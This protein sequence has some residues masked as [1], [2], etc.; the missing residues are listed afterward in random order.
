MLCHG[1]NFFWIPWKP[2]AFS[3]SP[4]AVGWP[5]HSVPFGVEGS[6]RTPQRFQ[7]RPGNLRISA[8]FPLTTTHVVGERLWF[9][10]S[11]SIPL[12]NQ[13]H[14]YERGWWFKQRD[15][16]LCPNDLSKVT[17][18][19]AAFSTVWGHVS[20]LT[21]SPSHKKVTWKRRIARGRP[22]LE[23]EFLQKKTFNKQSTWT[24]RENR[25]VG[26]EPPNKT[27]EGGKESSEM[28]SSQ[29]FCFFCFHSLKK[30]QS[31]IFPGSPAGY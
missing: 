27:F 7:R 19:P 26:E 8:G 16:N 3:S 30:I 29:R 17:I 2:L 18:R 15:Q 24:A 13:P 14:I 9:F 1:T 20:S 23:Q 21:H 6:L 12:T 10:S 5:P 4:G 31:P 22:L 28:S 11:V 25:Q